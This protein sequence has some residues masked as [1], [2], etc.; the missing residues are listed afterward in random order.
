MSARKTVIYASFV[1]LGGASVALPW[2]VLG[3]PKRQGKE[4]VLPNTY[5]GQ[6][7]I[8][9]LTREEAAKAVR[10]WW[11]TEKRTPVKLEGGP[12]SDLPEWTPSKLGVTLD[13]AATVATAPTRVIDPESPPKPDE[14]PEPR[15]DLVPIFKPNGQRPT[16]VLDW[17]KAKNGE[18]KSAKAFWRDGSIE[19]HHEASHFT[20]EESQLISRVVEALPTGSAVQLPVVEAKKDVPDED[21]EKIREV[22]MSY[23]T[24]F[25]ANPSRIQNLRVA[26]GKINGTVIMPG[27]KFSFNDVVG[28][29]SVKEGFKLAPILVRGQHATGIG[30]GIC[31]VCSTLYNCVLFADMKIVRRANHSVPVAYVPPGRDATV[32]FGSLDFVWQNTY[33]TPVAVTS[34][35]QGRT[36]TFRL[37]GQKKPGLKVVVYQKAM[38]TGNPGTNVVH[39]PNLPKG[40]RKVLEAGTPTRD[41]LT[42]RKVFQDGVLV[43]SEKLNRSRYGGQ[44]RVLSVGTGAVAP[45]DA[46]SPVA[47]VS[48]GA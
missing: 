32:S 22:V 45:T 44:P 41:F 14:T 33:D 46:P 15:H 10:T 2:V 29:R 23:S 24:Y 26:A 43:R 11:E 17:I 34:E 21:L 5:V 1:A 9:G 16:E 47:V 3:F 35:F 40:T 42:F 48:G 37:L 27:E 6:V 28:R 18:A 30:G 12:W 8:A 4:V 19:L 39:D 36:I 13:D 25:S 31:Q 20:I 7:K 38:G